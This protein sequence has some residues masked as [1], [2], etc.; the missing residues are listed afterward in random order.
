[1]PDILAVHF[2][3]CAVW[4]AAYKRSSILIGLVLFCGMLSKEIALLPILAW[5]LNDIWLMYRSEEPWKT[6]RWLPAVMVTLFLVVAVRWSF[7]VHTVLPSS[8]EHVPRTTF[9][10]IGMGWFGWLVPFPHYPVRDV[11]GF[12]DV[13]RLFGVGMVNSVLVYDS[14]QNGVVDCDGGDY[15]SVFHRFG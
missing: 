11:M 12:A 9:V 5:G 2:G 15:Y 14:K 13:V 6:P 8:F 3:L 10:T 7:Q 1:M 4:C